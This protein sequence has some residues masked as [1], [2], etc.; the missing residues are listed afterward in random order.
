MLTKQHHNTTRRQFVGGALAVI[1]GFPII[2]ALGAF[3]GGLDTA[4]AAS[5][6]STQRLL[7]VGDSLTVGS[8]PYQAAAF[9][10]NGWTDMAVNAHG[11][12]G[13][14]TKVS[15]DPYTGLT[16]VDALR[17]AHGDADLWVVA[18]G[19][20]D[21]GQYP[22]SQYPDLIASML[23]RI[24][25]DHLTM[26]VNTYMPTRA[27]LQVAWN[28]ALNEVA[29]QRPD[30]LVVFDWAAY[31]AGHAGW[32]G[33]DSIHY[34]ATGYRARSS[35]VAAAS[36]KTS[37]QV[38]GSRRTTD[39]PPVVTT[40][41]APAGFQPV[42]PV[43]ILDTR[44]SGSRLRA[45][46][47]RAIDLSSVVPSQATVVAINL[48]A[49]GAETSGFLTA[50]QLS[51]IPPSV[52]TVNFG[53]G[54]ATAGHAM[55]LLSP[56]T[57]LDVY[58]ST[59]TDLVADVF[60]WFAPD[61]PLGLKTATPSRLIDTRSTAPSEAPGS[62]LTLEIA[63][64]AGVTPKAAMLNIIAADATTNGFITVWPADQAM[65]YVSC[66]NYTAGMPAIA[67]LVQVGLDSS[68]RVSVFTSG[69]AAVVVDLI[70]TYDDRADSLRYQAVE[71]VRLLDTRSGRGGWLGP[72]ARDQA[73]DVPIPDTEVVA[74]GVLTVTAARRQG[75]LSTSSG[76][77]ILSLST[78]HAVSNVAVAR[79]APD[80]R[81]AITQTDGGGEHVVFDLTGWF[82]T[83]GQ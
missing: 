52:S 31:A 77:S 73:I 83:L 82:G 28:S 62:T 26:W 15:A 72:T 5:S 43:R 51:N 13:I 17:A 71:P 75:W 80:G 47:Q 12:R 79:P 55:A 27:R 44:V 9:I 74:A 34:T 20:N 57:I 76:T 33:A 1:G 67:N 11:S 3:T 60:G 46:E 19:T 45:G 66:L 6:T 10:D 50:G 42:P 38:S 53:A 70:A 58:S 56:G 22:A 37:Q 78:Q 29:V 7:M 30:E 63:S 48:T 4:N 23:N 8:L 69:R 18:L 14:K 16:A 39:T 36:T 68:G 41:I 24:G 40:V 61:A 32:L 25:A 35:A 59:T 81:L 54:D 21:A 64:S 49:V 2:D 65:P